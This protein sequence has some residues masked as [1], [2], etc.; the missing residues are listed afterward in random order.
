MAKVNVIVNSLTAGELTPRM[1][2]RVDTTKYRSG[3]R[4]IKNF[5]V[6]AHGGARKRG[7][8]KFIAP[9]KVGADPVQ[10][11]F[12]YNTEQTYLLEIGYAEGSGYIRFFTNGGILTETAQ[13]ITGATQT[14]PCVV[15]IAGH[16]YSNGDWVFVSGMSGG[17]TQLNNRHFKVANK[18]SD[19]FELQGVDATGYDAFSAGGTAGKIVEV[20]T[21]W[22]D[23]EE[24]DL[25]FTQ[26][27][28]VLYIAHGDYPTKK[29]SRLSAVSWTLTDAEFKS[30]PFRRI[31]SDR[32]NMIGVGVLPWAASVSAV[33]KANPC[34]VT[35]SAAHN[36]R[37]G[38]S[39][40]F[41]SVGGMTELNTNTY[42]VR[43]IDATS[44]SL[45]D[46]RGVPVDSSS[47]TTY[48]SGG[49]ATQID[50]KWGT[51]SPGT[52]VT[53]EALKPTFNP[54]H[55][56]AKWRL[57]EPGKGT[58]VMAPLGEFGISNTTQY[59]RDSKVYGVTN[60]ATSG[61][62]ANEWQPDWQYPSH[63]SGWVHVQDAGDTD[64]FDSVYL[65]DISCVIVITHYTSARVVHGYVQRNHVPI[66]LVGVATGTGVS[67]PGTY[68]TGISNANEKRTHY[69]EEGAWSDYRGYP[70]LIT[71]HEQRL[72]AAGAIGDLQT[73]YASAAGDFE[74]FQDGTDDDKAV[75]Y[76]VQSD[77]VEAPR[78]LSPAKIL[79][80]GTAS[81]EFTISA[82]GGRDEPI[83]PANC[84]IV[85]QTR[86]G[87]APGRVIGIG[88][89][90]LFL[91]RFG[92]P[93]NYA[94]KVRE[95]YYD[96]NTDAFVAPDMTILSEHLGNAQ[97]VNATY[98]QDPDP[99]VWLHRA[100]GTFCGL[101]YEKEQQVLG[102]H[103]HELEGPGAFVKHMR[104]LPGDSGDD[105]WMIVEREV[106]GE[107]VRYHE[108]LTNDD[109][110]TTAKED[111]RFLD[112]HLSYDGAPTSTVSGLWHL[113]GETVRVLA[114]GAV[115]AL[116]TV[117][118]GKITLTRAASKIHVGYSYL[119]ELETMDL[120]AGA[121]AGTAHGRPKRI[122][123][124]NAKFYRSLGGRIGTSAQMDLLPSR[125]SSDPMDASPPL[126]S[127]FYPISFPA[128]WEDEA[129]V[130]LEHDDP[131]PCNLMS[132]TVSQNVTG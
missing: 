9:V 114:D 130:R 48:T 52:I 46:E 124:V 25:T 93:G 67:T 38:A 109:I 64:K 29:L 40:I 105:V 35:V 121:Q 11:D 19:T 76:R 70:K 21:P 73:I 106:N 74:D 125:S 87:S 90:S 30:G 86:W 131:L 89:A 5:I 120:E 24:A 127:G 7:G 32:D 80:M 122:S 63:D 118:D 51:L 10:A 41:G 83:T 84:R 26:S 47:F 36:L 4:L 59:T 85:K 100:D 126:F 65:H 56:G 12:Q 113:E 111:S 92:K 62:Y 119:S 123:E 96:F 43:V 54:S 95:F 97:F 99:I 71:G 18:T 28:D 115:H 107:T 112:C 8:S 60:L 53:L 45:C 31:N 49:T 44:F 128:G 88:S 79:M 117:M 42:E 91:Q 57:W 129:V 68:G 110:N 58:G 108:V 94:R 1:S 50:T 104:A 34:V 22:G 66:S 98:A 15:T 103:Q 14:N 23:G 69:H 20:A 116:V 13:T 61:D 132:F 101:T 78:W 55:V 3:A 102:W 39:V 72:W 75:V 17:M 16:G 37:D 33:T 27:A 81:G 82:A 77:K 6:M 2:A